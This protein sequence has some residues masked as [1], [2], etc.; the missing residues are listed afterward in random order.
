MSLGSDYQ[1]ALSYLLAVPAAKRRRLSPTGTWT[2][3]E[4]LAG[5]LLWNKLC[6]LVILFTFMLVL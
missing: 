1:T 4:R 3:F 2:E 6:Y 5:Q